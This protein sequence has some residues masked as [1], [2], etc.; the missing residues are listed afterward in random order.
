MFQLRRLCAASLLALAFAAFATCATAEV[1]YPPGSRIGLEP[2]GGLTLSKSFPGFEDTDRQVAITILDLP[3]RAYE[4]IERSVFAKDQGGL[5]D[6]KR[7]SFPFA[8]GIGFLMKGQM[9][10]NGVSTHKWF[11]LAIA[12]GGQVRDLT[13]LVN[14]QVPET[15]RAAYPDAVIRKMLASITFRPTPL[16]EQIGLLPFKLNDMAGFRVMQALPAGG[17]ILTDGP[18]D[19]I[20]A[21]SYMIVSVGRGAPN[22]PADRGKFSR[23]MLL[24]APLNNLA[25]TLAE[26]MRI[27]GQQGFEI[28]AQAEGLN[29]APLSVVQWIRFGAG[30]YL[31]VIG[32]SHKDEWD[33]LFTRFR[34]VRDGIE[35]R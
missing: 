34:A 9:P 1:I 32:V 29:G 15:A 18:T 17:V 7:E 30:G 11:L 33:A 22:E 13:M 19:N 24:S 35:P 14:A 2:Q 27:G 26:P 10:V 3:A 31:R 21:Q 20:A 16:A 8:S 23:E 4:E 12:V 25:V 6:L 5:T 28:R